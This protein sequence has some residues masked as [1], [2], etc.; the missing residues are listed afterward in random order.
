MLPTNSRPRGG[1]QPHHL[2][3]TD[4]TQIPSH[5][6]P[7]LQS[8]GDSTYPIGWLQGRGSITVCLMQGLAHD[9]HDS[10]SEWQGRHSWWQKRMGEEEEGEEGEDASWTRW[11]G[12]EVSQKDERAAAGQ[13]QRDPLPCKG[14]RGKASRLWSKVQ[15]S[16][17]LTDSGTF[18]S[19]APTPPKMENPTTAGKH[20]V[21]GPRGRSWPAPA[22]GFTTSCVIGKQPLCPE[23]QEGSVSAL[24]LLVSAI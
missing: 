6:V 4:P 1:F 12:P 13:P 16:G 19:F 5:C 23:S 15:I 3:A 22:A 17:E 8:G 7:R 9:Q 24:L 18:P 10:S 2:L 20:R 21:P 14:K 11:M